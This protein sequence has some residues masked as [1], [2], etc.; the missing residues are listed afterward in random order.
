MPYFECSTC[1]QLAEIGD[2]EHSSLRQYC[3]VCETQ[4]TWSIA[5]EDESGVTF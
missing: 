3:P 5:F 2:L 1:G 4:T